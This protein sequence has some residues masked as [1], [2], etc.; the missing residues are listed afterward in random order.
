MC[1]PS[2]P[3]ISHDWIRPSHRCSML[4]RHTGLRFVGLFLLVAIPFVSCT[5]PTSNV[6]I[7]THTL[8]PNGVSHTVTL[9]GPN[10]LVGAGDIASCTSTGDDLTAKL[11]DTIPGTVFTTGDNVYNAATLSEFTNC[12]NP[13]WGRQKTRTQPVPGDKEYGDPNAPNA[14][15][16]FSYFGSAFGDYTTGY[17]S[18]NLGTWHVIMLNSSVSMSAKS[19]QDA[20]LEGDLAANPSKCTLAIWD[21]PR[22]YTNGVRSGSLAIWSDLY[23]AGVELVVN[24]HQ[25]NYERF[26]PMKPDGTLDTLTGIRQ[27]I[28]ATG[29]VSHGSFGTPVQAN[30]EV[31]NN[32]AYGV[33]KLT[34]NDSSYAWQ[35]IPVQ[36]QTFTDAGTGKCHGTPAPTANTGGPYDAEN[37]VVFDGT[38]SSDPGGT[39]ITYA[40]NF[41]DGASGTGATPSHIYTANG[42]YTVTLTVTNASGSPSTPAQTTVTIHNIAPT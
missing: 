9:S 18:Y 6:R 34:L 16:Y 1:D 36:G 40:W 13:T 19:A 26:A 39:A 21:Q 27:I 42:M 41:G 22:F 11:L 29:G 25:R 4:S 24:G 37:V 3:R 17:Y 28:A 32:A 8:P 23:G 35:F 2:A 30:S 20:W 5:D 31:R 7:P 38:N 14:S 33:L 15:G 10:V 12:Y